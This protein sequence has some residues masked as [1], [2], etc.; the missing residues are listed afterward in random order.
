MARKRRGGTQNMGCGGVL[1]G[2]FALLL[3]V[4]LVVD[5]LKWAVG[6][7]PVIAVF[8][9]VVAVAYAAVQQ[10][11][12]RNDAPSGRGTLGVLAIEDA[13]SPAERRLLIAR[14]FSRLAAATIERCPPTET[15]PH[16]DGTLAGL[17]REAELL[18]ASAADP[19]GGPRETS[20]A[21]PLNAIVLLDAA[22]LLVN[23]LG[24]QLLAAAA[25][26]L[27]TGE[28]L[29]VVRRDRTGLIQ[30]NDEITRRVQAP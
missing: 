20:T 16:W 25:M 21:Q 3:V 6:N 13:R 17:A 1:V 27:P 2:L 26:P 4:G 19:V 14:E 7:W 28:Q 9:V 5:L 11:K 8:A 24:E 10:Y 30:M 22:Q 23:F 18:R 29:R 15:R 12:R